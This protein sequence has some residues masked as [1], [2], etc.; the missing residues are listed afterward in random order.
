MSLLNINPM[1]ATVKVEINVPT[2]VLKGR[3]IAS[4]AAVKYDA[5]RRIFNR[6]KAS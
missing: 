4:A 2:M 6:C 5:N 3:V 1:P